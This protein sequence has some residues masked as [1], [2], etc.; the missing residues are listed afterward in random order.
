MRGVFLQQFLKHSVGLFEIALTQF[1]D[2]AIE[3]SAPL[4]SRHA[5]R[6]VPPWTRLVKLK[7]KAAKR[8]TTNR[9]GMPVI[10]GILRGEGLGAISAKKGGVF[11]DAAPIV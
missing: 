5:D 8:I 6:S 1:R 11:S 9:M 4:G 10:T 3:L 7:V 2:G